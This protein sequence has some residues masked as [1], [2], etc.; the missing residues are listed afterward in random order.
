MDIKPQPNQSDILVASIKHIKKMISLHM[1]IIIRIH[2]IFLNNILNLIIKGKDTIIRNELRITELA[3]ITITIEQVIVDYI[4][5]VVI[6]E[7][8]KSELVHIGQ[9]MV[10][11]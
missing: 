8:V 10:E 3:I 2:Q 11:G 5:I 7:I 1:V 9:V 6:Y 4:I